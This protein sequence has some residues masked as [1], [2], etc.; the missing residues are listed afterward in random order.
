MPSVNDNEMLQGSIS[1][2]IEGLKST[3]ADLQKEFGQSYKFI[4]AETLKFVA[5]LE[6]KYGQLTS[7]MKDMASKAIEAGKALGGSLKDNANAQNADKII[8]AITNINKAQKSETIAKWGKALQEALNVFSVNKNTG[9]TLTA[10]QL[11]KVF[12]AY[13]E[14][15]EK[16][17]AV[18]RE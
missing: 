7:V 11:E 17:K 16:T 3:M 9:I 4:D 14:G 13:A 15:V 8:K 6:Q 5:T 2:S 18:E 1:L 12:T 10:S